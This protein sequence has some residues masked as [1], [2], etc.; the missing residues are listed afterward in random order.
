MFPSRAQSFQELFD[1][2]NVECDQWEGMRLKA[3]RQRPP[4][5][6][7]HFVA[8]FPFF[9]PRSLCI[10]NGNTIVIKLLL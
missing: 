8:L 10:F 1:R 4:R 6:F 2:I 9:L 5:L 3:V 7:H